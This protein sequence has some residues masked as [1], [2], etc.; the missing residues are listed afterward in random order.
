MDTYKEVAAAW[1]FRAVVKL[2]T[3]VRAVL[4]DRL[5]ASWLAAAALGSAV[6]FLVGV[7]DQS[8]AGRP[9]ANLRACARGVLV[10]V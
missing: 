9:L 3:L 6:L 10:V 1:T 5:K 2:A 8:L 4:L 7:S